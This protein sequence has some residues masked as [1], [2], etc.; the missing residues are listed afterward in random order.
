MCTFDDNLVN[1]KYLDKCIEITDT[2][3]T[4][5]STNTLSYKLV[6][7]ICDELYINYDIYFK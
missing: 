1:L 6:S 3:T 7:S 5:K 2:S 4:N